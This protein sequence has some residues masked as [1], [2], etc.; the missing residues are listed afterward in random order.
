MNIRGESPSRDERMIGTGDVDKEK[1]ADFIHWFS[2][3]S[4]M[5]YTRALSS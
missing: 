3:N 1:M 2:T 4:S 5:V